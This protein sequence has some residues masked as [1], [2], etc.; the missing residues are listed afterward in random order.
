VKGLKVAVHEIHV[1]DFA[2]RRQVIVDDRRRH[3]LV[4]F[5][6]RR[7]ELGGV[8]PDV[9]PTLEPDLKNNVVLVLELYKARR[10]GAVAICLR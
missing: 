1:A 3:T 9:R 5:G 8:F 2:R 7:T 6:Q 10:A 4:E